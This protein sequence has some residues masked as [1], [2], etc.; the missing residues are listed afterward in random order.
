M[1]DMK[2]IV[3]AI[4]MICVLSSCSTTAHL[5]E[6]TTSSDKGTSFFDSTTDPKLKAGDKLTISIWGHDDLSIGSVNTVFNSNESTGKWV[7]IDKE[8]EVNLPKLG[9][10][11][12]A[13][14]SVKEV[15][16][17]LE[18]AYEK[19]IQNPII[20]VKVLNHYVTVLGEVNNPGKYTLENSAMELVELLAE[21]GGM[22]KYAK[23]TAVDI[24]RTKDTLSQKLTVDLTDFSKFKESNI[25]LFP[26]DVVYIPPTKEKNR[27]EGL[28]KAVPVVSIL[29]GVAVLVSVFIK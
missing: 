4:L 23:N 21:A 25:A 11:K 19:H 2:V 16:Y 12:L 13:D 6:N 3:S 26:D 9:R 8:G 10:I 20:N 18:Q 14:Y 24:I 15:N 1:P 28:S 5:F 7:V 27:D 29:T 17:L 22:T